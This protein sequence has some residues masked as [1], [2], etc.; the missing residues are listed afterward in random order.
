MTTRAANLC[1]WH[2]R[3]K[4]PWAPTKFYVAGCTECQ[5]KVAAGICEAT[6]PTP[7]ELSEM[8]RRKIVFGKRLNQLKAARKRMEL[9]R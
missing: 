4:P 5:R 8:G 3:G 6:D 9:G 7:G 2:F 1:D